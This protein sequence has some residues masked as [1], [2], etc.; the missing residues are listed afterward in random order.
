VI[1]WLN[2]TFGA[3]KTTT[4]AELLT[5]LPGSRRPLPPPQP[6]SVQFVLL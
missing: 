3:G 5:L 2:G 1:I 6:E 4:A